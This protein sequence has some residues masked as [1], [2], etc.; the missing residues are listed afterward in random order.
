[1]Y[2]YLNLLFIALC[3]C[4]FTTQAQNI[5][6]FVEEDVMIETTTGKLYGTLLLPNDCKKCGVALLIA[7]SGATD[8]NGNGMGIEPNTLKLI[9]ETLAKQNIASLRYD[10]RGIGQSKEALKSENE[11]IFAHAIEDAVAWLSFLKINQKFDKKIIIGHS[12]GSL[13][14]MVAAQ[15]TDTQAFISIAGV[16]K[17]ADQIISQQLENQINIGLPQN[18][19]DQASIILKE[20]KNGHQVTEVLPMFAPLFRPSVQ[21]YLISWFSYTPT[22]EIAKLKIPILVIQGT[23][24]LQVPTIEAENLAKAN[25]LAKLAIM[26]GMNPMS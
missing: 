12:E 15:K 17:S 25:P 22:E 8:R 3:I 18:L 11:L 1:M 10:K 13:I 7:G 23:T 20:L 4:C 16:A 26:E 9:A 21:P 24:D 19:F 6:T 5:A 14:G 2:G